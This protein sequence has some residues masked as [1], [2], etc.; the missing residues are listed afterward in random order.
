MM[1]RT[2][3]RFVALAAVVLA[4]VLATPAWAGAAT[5]YDTS[6]QNGGMLLL[7]SVSGIYGQVTQSCQ[8]TGKN[9]SIA[10]RFGYNQPSLPTAWK[11]TQ[12]LGITAVSVRTRQPMTLGVANV[13]WK[14][15]RIPTGHVVLGEAFG[16]DGSF[17]YVTRSNRKSQRTKLKLFRVSASGSRVKTFGHNGYISITVPGFDALRPAGFRV[18]V[19]ASGRVTLI[20]QTAT[21]QVILRYNVKGRPEETFGKSGVVELAAPTTFPGTPL[22]AAD[23]AVLTP[24]DGL[25]LAANN[26]PGKPA[27]STLGILKLTTAGN[28][29]A[30][31]GTAGLWTPPAPKGVSTTGAAYNVIGQTLL[32]SNRKGGGYAFLYADAATGAGEAGTTSDLKLA[33]VDKTSGVTT[34]A[35]ELAST[36]N[37]G[38][39]GG[40]PD[41]EPW[42]LGLAKAGTIF[43]KAQSFYDS[44]GGTRFGDAAR[45][46]ADAAKALTARQISNSGFAAGDFAVDPAS[47][48]LYFCGSYGVTS[49]KAKDAARR[50]QRKMVAVKRVAL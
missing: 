44:P 4:C 24:E 29:A 10:G 30:T 22:N 8:V 12:K 17:A 25:L 15:Q 45:F 47:N 18:F 46:S 23:S 2:T 34:V 3:S 50:E 21:T 13:R 16:Q 26:A 31:W 6:Y 36:Y 5:K 32:T 40:F 20:A 38:G 43:A 27:Q 11:T 41:A 39:D 35:N 7:P 33:Y 19:G 49:A 42:K 14:M 28:V 37:N 1:I 9:L 48:Y